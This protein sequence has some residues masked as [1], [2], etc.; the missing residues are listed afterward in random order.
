MPMKKIVVTFGLISGALSSAMMVAFLPFIDRIGFDRGFLFGYTAIVLSF[1]LVF[2]GIR[3]YREKA[4]GSL[5]FGRGFT[6]GILITLI[7]CVFYVITWE[8]VYFNF[9][10]DFIEKF[11]AYQI[12]HVRASGAGEEEIQ[13]KRRE[14]EDFKKKYQN[15]FFNAA[16]TFT[17]PFPIG[18]LVTVVSA[19]VLRTKG[20]PRPETGQTARQGA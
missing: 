3:A 1:L 11:G 10:P 17:E 19:A 7:S 15:P 5:T 18:L 20:R 9:M 6:V 2:F 14:V 4:G 12:E 13:S 16:V 8:I